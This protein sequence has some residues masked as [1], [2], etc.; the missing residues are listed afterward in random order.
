MTRRA[1][2]TRPWTSSSGRGPRRVRRST[3]THARLAW[4]EQAAAQQ[5][6][7]AHADGSYLEALGANAG[8][9]IAQMNAATELRDAMHE[10]AM[11]EA[12]GQAGRSAGVR[13]TAAVERIAAAQLEAEA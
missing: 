8:L 4:Y 9:Q 13:D 10:D 11:L 3:R 6:Q 5:L 1:S 12:A 2:T 7:Q